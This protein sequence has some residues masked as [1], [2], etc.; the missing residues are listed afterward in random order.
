MG[1]VDWEMDQMARTAAVGCAE[2]RGVRC[3]PFFR[4]VPSQGTLRSAVEGKEED[5]LYLHVG[6]EVVYVPS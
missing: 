6:Q 2:A 3:A 4:Q 5:G 1:V